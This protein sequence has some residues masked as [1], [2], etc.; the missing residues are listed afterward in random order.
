MTHNDEILIRRLLKKNRRW[1]ERWSVFED[2]I[3]DDLAEILRGVEA[4]KR[5]TVLGF[6]NRLALDENGVILNSPDNT[7]TVLEMLKSVGKL[8]REIIEPGAPYAKWVTKNFEKSG[9]M[10]IRKALDTVKIADSAR[11]PAKGYRARSAMRQVTQARDMMFRQ[12]HDR[13]N[14]DLG[15]LRR[16][17]M[18]NITDP[19]GNADTLRLELTKSGQIEG[20]LDSAGRRVTA[21]E[22]ADRIARYEP[23]TLARKAHDEAINDFYYDGQAPGLDEQYRLWDAT[24]DNRTTASHARR[25]QKVLTVE[26]WQTHEWG[27]GQYGLP[28]TRPRCRCDGIWVEPSW[29][30]KG[31]QEKHFENRLRVEPMEEAA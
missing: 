7:R 25:H 31:T 29:F 8:N 17:F 13:G 16:A 14:M 3:K 27:D 2:V 22:R 5:R 6:I 12:V 20:M 26:E 19:Q 4:T 30:S 18:R 23:Q 11:L 28:P 21:S 24:M 1:Q 9:V 10:G 15:V